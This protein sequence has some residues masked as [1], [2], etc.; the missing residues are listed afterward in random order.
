MSRR[1][2]KDTGPLV[3]LPRGDPP[4]L[5]RTIPISRLPRMRLCSSNPYAQVPVY[6]PPYMPMQRRDP[7]LKAASR[8]YNRMWLLMLLQ[9][10]LAVVV[11]GAIL[12]VNNIVGLVDLYSGMGLQLFSTAMVPISTALPF[13]VYLK[14]GRKDVETYLRF[15]Q[16]G[17]FQ[18][19]L[20]VL[21]GAGLCILGNYPA[22]LVQEFFGQ[23]GYEATNQM[24]GAEPSWS[25]FLVEFLSTAVLVPVMEEFAFRGV[26]FSALERHGTGFAVIGSALVFAFA[27]LDFSIVLFAFVAGLT[28]AFVYARTRNLWVTVA[29]HAVNNGLAVIGNYADFLFGRQAELISM[30][31]MVVPMALGLLALIVLMI[32]RRRDLFRKGEPIEGSIFPPLTGGEGAGCAIRA[33]LFWVALSLVVVYTALLFV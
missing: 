17:V 27:H 4:T 7:R 10:L 22:F 19:L 32:L 33:P 30:L 18:S 9:T 12:L 2:K 13:L 23:F 15:E 29:I 1:C 28:L 14:I 31:T 16:N 5:S 3:F 20:F 21:A 8:T 11:E 25:I 26:V 6:V 24:L